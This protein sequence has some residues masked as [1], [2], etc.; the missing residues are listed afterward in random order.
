MSIALY[1][2][3]TQEESNRV[4]VGANSLVLDSAFFLK[5]T[6]NVVDKAGAGDVIV[7]VNNTEATFAA[8]NVTVAKATVTYVP[9]TSNRLYEVAT[10]AA[11][12]V[13][14]ETKYYNLTAAGIV[15]AATESTVPY[16]VDT[17]VGAAVDPVISLQVQL[18]KF[19][20]GSL[21]AFKIVNL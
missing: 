8:D 16:Y 20:N 17:T 14:D 7:G 1:E 12:T 10:S 3:N 11:I 21:G 6:G 2:N 5:S 19:I 13:D 4:G 15:D 9:K 18:V